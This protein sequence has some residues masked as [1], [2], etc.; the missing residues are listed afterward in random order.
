MERQRIGI[1][2]YIMRLIN[3]I[4]ILGLLLSYLAQWI[5][6]EV[7]WPISFFG[8]AYPILI[9]VNILFL[10]HWIF[11]RRKFLI[12]PLLAIMVGLPMLGRF[13]QFGSNTEVIDA[14]NNLKIITYNVHVLDYYHQHYGGS[15]YAGDLILEK[16]KLENADIYCMQEFYCKGD[17][18]K[19][20]ISKYKEQ[21]NTPYTYHKLYGSKNSNIAN[22]IFSKYPII[23][24][25]IVENPKDKYK[26][27]GIFADIELN[28]SEIRIYSVHLKSIHISGNIDLMNDI[29]NLDTEEGQQKAKDNSIYFINKFKKAFSERSVQISSLKNHIAN[30]PFPVIIAGDFNDTPSSYAYSQL[31]DGLDDAFVKKGGGFGQT[32]IGPYPSFRIDNILFDP[33]FTCTDYNTIKIKLSDHY[34]ISAEF[35]IY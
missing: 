1:I 28:G 29:S 20:L 13:V 17:K 32:Y 2:G 30:S 10:T 18:G 15:G 5:S 19:I 11:R 25:G 26:I 34:P 8:L 16:M 35:G 6:P 22:V 27:P 23:R 4:F 24:N 3:W 14:S 33:Q 31:R 21:L 7:F 9:I 12:Y